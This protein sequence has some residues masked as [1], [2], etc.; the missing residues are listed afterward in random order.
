MEK[1]GDLRAFQKVVSDMTS[2]PYK[3]CRKIR[4]EMHIDIVTRRDTVQG[5]DPCVLWP[6]EKE[7]QSKTKIKG[8]RRNKKTAAKSRRAAEIEEKGEKY[9]GIERP[10]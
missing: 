8:A 7:N 10:R 2:E 3:I 9:G 6:E 4:P 5:Q 1:Y